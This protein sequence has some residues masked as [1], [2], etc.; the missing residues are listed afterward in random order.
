MK[1]ACKTYRIGDSFDFR[2][3][4]WKLDGHFLEIRKS[5]VGRV[6]FISSRPTDLTA[7]LK[8]VIATP[9]ILERVPCGV[10][11]FC[12]L[13][14]PGRPASYVKTAIKNQDRCLRFD[15][16][17]TSLHLA[18]CP[19]EEVESDCL[20]WGVPF[21]P[22]YNSRVDEV[23][24]REL[25]E[26]RGQKIEGYVF[27]NGNRL[28][29]SKWKPIKTIDLIV[30]GVT[31]GKGKYKG[32]VG[33]LICETFEKCEV[34]RVSGMDDATREDIDSR[35]IGK[36]I[37]VAYQNVGSKGR[38]TFPRFVRWRPDKHEHNCCLTQDPDLM[39]YWK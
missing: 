29:F 13:W 24:Q 4:H 23:F 27:K 12:E 26:Y 10:T 3:A 5:K 22:F 20:R 34:A 14:L 2:Y 25:P 32:Q 1:L 9:A 15:V 37:E 17:A 28:G 6:S 18:S 38:L 33:A 19:L 39:E 36:V 35:V 11:L 16:F 30:V 7:Q 8:G 31:N 21:V